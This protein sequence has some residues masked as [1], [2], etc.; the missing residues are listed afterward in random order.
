MNP[1][2][3]S[4]IIDLRPRLSDRRAQIGA[5]ITHN[6]ADHVYAKLI[7]TSLTPSSVPIEGI[8]DCMAVLPAAVVSITANSSAIRSR[9][10]GLRG[11][12][13][14]GDNSLFDI[15]LAATRG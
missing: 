2:M 12:S 11:A 15:A 5:Q 1:T 7:H 13:V 9:E 4:A 14:A 8:T 3:P 6:S 10:I